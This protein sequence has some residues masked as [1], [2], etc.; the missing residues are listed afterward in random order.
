MG[1]RAA[2]GAT[3][4]LLDLFRVDGRVAIVTGAGSGLGAG[5]ARALAESGADIVLSGR[6][7]DPLRRTADT[8]R[9]LGRR[10]LE[11]PSDVTDPE[12]CDAVVGAAIDEFGRVDIL[13]NNAGLTHTAPAT[14]ELPEVSARFSTSTSSGATGWHG[15]VHG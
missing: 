12:Q 3:T 13:I 8:V 7:P 4:G 15:P 10:A 2:D 14:R 5:F 1:A 6:R 9:A 11:I